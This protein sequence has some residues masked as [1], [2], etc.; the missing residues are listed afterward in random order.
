MRALV[1]NDHGG[2]E[3][4]AVQNWPEPTPAPGRVG[5]RV[6]AAGLN[7]ADI[8]SV[9]GRYQ[10]K[11]VPPFVP[12]LEVAGTVLWVGDG[13]DGIAPG[14]V[15]AAPLDGGGFADQVSAAGNAVVPVPAGLDPVEAAGLLIN[16]GTAHLALTHRAALAPGESLLISGAAGG[17]GLA[18]VA[19]GK[20][21]G[22][23]VIALAGGQDKLA[24]AASAGAD[25]GVDYRTED[26]RGRVKALT[27]D[28]GADVV[29]DTVGG[30][31]FDGAFR[32]TARGGRILVIGF[33]S[34]TV[35][36]VPA[37]IAMVKNIALHGVN[38]GGYRDLDPAAYQASTQQLLAWAA[39]G[40]IRPQISRRVDLDSIPV[41]LADL[42]DRKTTGKV[43]AVIG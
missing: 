15:V 29:F 41:A 39:E 24:L 23:R 20:A 32:A 33:A 26:I 8:L 25:A 2:L 37:N 40:R 34:G 14:D 6:A 21:L 38:W 18:A 28:R 43:V 5:I 11:H 13:V 22:A 16:F 7:F 35:P 12:G 19:V 17:T 1:C 9:K 10:I 27:E 42:A 36:A 3:N 31:A 4:L 30:S